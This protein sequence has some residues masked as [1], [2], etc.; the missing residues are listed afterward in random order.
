[1]KRQVEL[2]AI[3]TL[4]LLL[5]AASADQERSAGLGKLDRSGAFFHPSYAS[6]PDG[7]LVETAGEPIDAATYLRYLSARF[8]KRFAADMTFDV[9]LARECKARGLV[10]T[11]PLMARSAASARTHAT[12]RD[13]DSARGDDLRRKFAIEELRRLRVNALVG[14][15]RASD[16]ARIEEL[17]NRRY[18]VGGHKVVIRQ[19]LVSFAATE[20]REAAAGR[21]TDPA[22]LE[23]AAKRRADDLRRRARAGDAF[24]DLLSASDDR[25]TRRMLRDSRRAERAG[26]V[27]GYNY[28]RY[29]EAFAEAVR[30]LEVGA[31][32]RPVK[33][34]IGY[35]IIEL[36][37]RKITK[38]EDV[39]GKIQSELRAK[40]ASQ[41][42]TMALRGHLFEKHRVRI[43]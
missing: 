17:F 38:V 11:A 37:D 14:L 18:G 31:V 41:S 33:T 21:S 3:V 8:G 36:V 28:R 43:K 23:A 22:A 4:S 10:R 20:A 16:P 9:L 32:S 39:I 27:E 13:A 35:H 7:P 26:I 6:A 42:E 34:D 1:M 5:V 12:G 19:I 2:F 24:T 29:G 15:R 40:A 30:S 25:T